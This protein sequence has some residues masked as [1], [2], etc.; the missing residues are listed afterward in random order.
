MYEN[1]NNID[2]A[3]K[4]YKIS[5]DMMESWALNKV[6][7]YYRLKGD[8]KTAYLYYSKSIECPLNERN[9][10][11]YYNLAE[12]YYKN[13][14]KELNIKKDNNKYKEYIDMFNKLKK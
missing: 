10:Y 14:F 3:I 2:E 9:R 4:Y 7:E 12:Y 11:A 1:E 8:L 5:A 6:G 13:G